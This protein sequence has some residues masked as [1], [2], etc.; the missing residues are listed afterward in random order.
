MA[1][2]AFVAFTNISPVRLIKE[3][4]GFV[5]QEQQLDSG[6]IKY[7][8][9]NRINTRSRDENGK[10]IFRDVSG[11]FLLTK[12]IT[13][14]AHL[15]LT[16]DSSE[17]VTDGLG[18]LLYR[19]RKDAS[20]LHLTSGE[21]KE[22]VTGLLNDVGGRLVI[23]RSTVRNKRQ[24]ATV[25]YQTE[26]LDHLYTEAAKD[27][28]HVHSF[29]FELFD[30]TKERLLLN[31]SLNRE[32]KFSFYDGELE[33]FIRGLVE[34]ATHIVKKREDILQNRA[35]SEETGR[36][37]PIRITFDEPVFEK[38]AA[39]RA[40]LTTISK[41]RHGEFTI[42]H[43]NPYLHV[44]FF[45]FFDGSEYELFV[46]SAESILVVPQFGSTTPS[47][48]RFCQKI[49]ENFQEGIVSDDL[50]TVRMAVK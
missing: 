38:P 23:R 46:D 4:R 7:F 44:S 1:A 19:I 20:T 17:F 11:T 39:I 31:A 25:S 8:S 29:A 43:R 32:G 49:F 5:M 47:L 33:L 15:F 28:A 6:G 40:F 9:K 3:A 48:F 27:D 41:I 21:M 37:N 10:L 45:D 18:R 12:L 14:T 26:F 34:K 30:K 36:I 24:E 42:F 35:R 22:V 2:T 13:P 50:T 16:K